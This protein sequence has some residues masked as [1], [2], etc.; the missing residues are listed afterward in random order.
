M[1]E[2]SDK[3]TRLYGCGWQFP[4]RFHLDMSPSVKSS[5]AMSTDADNVA[6]SLALLFQTQPG[7]RIMRP[8]YGCDMHSFMFANLSEG[9]L[10]ALR[11]RIAESVA[12]HEPRAE[13][14]TIELQEVG[15]QW[16]S[17]RITVR[18]CLAGQ[19]RQVSGQMQRL[20]G[21]D[22]GTTWALS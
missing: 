7:E 13:D 15:R 12:R 5:V 4:L 10:A 18:Y 22:G 8:A 6:Q 21:A 11:N 17:L 16:G 19:P 20:E 1:N 3:L 14:V 2:Q 9:T